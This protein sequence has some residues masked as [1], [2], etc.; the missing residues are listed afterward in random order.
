MT[1]A[2]HPLF[3]AYCGVCMQH[4]QWS[5]ALSEDYML[6]YLAQGGPLHLKHGGG[7]DGNCYQ[8]KILPPLHPS[9]AFLVHYVVATSLIFYAH[10]T[11]LFDATHP[12][13]YNDETTIRRQTYIS[14][15]FFIYTLILFTTRYL[16]SYH[17]GRL[18]H[19]SVLYELTWCC[20]F[21][22]VMGCITFCG[23]NSTS[24]LFRR[25]PL[26]A[27]ACCVA[28]S[29]DQILWYVDL[30]VWLTTGKFAVGV[31]KYLTWKQ[32]LW[33]DRITCT[34]HLWCIPLILYGANTPLDFNSVKLSAFIVIIN[35][36]LSR[37]LTPHCI[38]IQGGTKTKTKDGEYKKDPKHY[39]YLN[40]NL[41]H[42]LWQDIK[43]PFLQISKD[44]PKCYVYL[45][46]LLWRWQLLNTLV[47]IAV[48][49]PLSK[50]II[51]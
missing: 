45:F 2:R 27:T 8:S 47:Y 5:F 26:V 46:R 6:A 51:S 24:W 25:R 3:I 14:K 35:V 18:R 1:C 17:A 21:T 39:R 9:L 40:V 44:N 10:D 48:L 42:E 12:T 34:H 30:I 7:V 41:S 33:I 19:Y 28:V 22:L 31:I 29:I 4:I 38:Q 43:L 23:G 13:T 50:W 15:F 16:S 36:L 37:W 49:C 32:T 20:N 11:F